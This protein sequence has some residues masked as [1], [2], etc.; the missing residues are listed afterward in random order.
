MPI[1]NPTYQAAAREYG[2]LPHVL[3]DDFNEHKVDDFV[4]RAQH[5][6]DLYEEGQDS[7]EESHTEADIKLIRRFIKKW[8]PYRHL[9]RPPEAPAPAPKKAKVKVKK[10]NASAKPAVKKVR[11]S[12]LVESLNQRLNAMFGVR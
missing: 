10:A 12:G 11:S 5:E 2:A 7:V 4:F 3:H 6:V 8:T 9:V 1:K